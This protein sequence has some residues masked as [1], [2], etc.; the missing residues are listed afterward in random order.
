MPETTSVVAVK[1]RYSPKPNWFDP[2]LGEYQVGDLVLVET[3]RGREVGRVSAVG[4]E[5]S[6]A[7]LRSLNSALR[8]VVRQL[9]EQDLMQMERMTEKSGAAMPLFRELVERSG[10]EMKPVAIEYLF[11][12][13]KAVFYFASESRV[14]FRELVREMASKLHIRVELRQIGVRDEARMIGGISHCGEKLCC[15]RMGVDFQPVSIRMAKEQDLPLNPEK[16]SGACGRLMCCLRY[17]FEA[18]KDFKGRAPKRGAEIDTPLGTAKVTDYDTPREVVTMRLE[19]G[20]T[21]AVP[22]RDFDQADADSG[23]GKRPISISREALERT[24]NPTTL[25]AL[26]ALDRESLSDDLAKVGADAE[27]S[28]RRQRRSRGARRTDTQGG[29]DGASGKAGPGQAARRASTS[30][31]DSAGGRVARQDRAGRQPGTDGRGSNR[32]QHSAE[33]ASGAAKLSA[34]QAEAYQPGA[35]DTGQSRRQA[36]PGRNSSG[37]RRGDATTAARQAANT[38]RTSPDP[39][40]PAADAGDGRRRRRRSAKGDGE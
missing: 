27:Y 9:D 30:G 25:L 10:L 2:V 36:R 15:A 34:R 22:L 13:D 16:I 12:G 32:R 17:E 18:Y 23:E 28:T 14:D 37:L 35:G 21:I 20:K 3:E 19:D 8:P 11:G 33:A 40:P 31:A 38:R 5:A 29:S 4:I 7:Q 26:S 24:A 1:L 39:A 6:P